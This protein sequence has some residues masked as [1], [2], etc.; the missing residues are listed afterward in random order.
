[1]RYA[2]YWWDGALGWYWVSVRPYDPQLKRWLQPD[3]SEQDGVRTYAYASSFPERGA[4]RPSRSTIDR[5]L[6]HLQARVAEGCEDAAVLWRE[7]SGEERKGPR[8]I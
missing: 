5:H 8:I 1:L 3:P 4:R 2:G 6:P 7:L